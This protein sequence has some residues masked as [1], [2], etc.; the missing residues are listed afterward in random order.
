MTRLLVLVFAILALA[1]PALA[2][3]AAPTIL[4]SIDGFR[5]DYLGQGNTPNLDALVARGARAEMR[6]SFPTKTFPNHS[7]I[8]SG[9]V[10]DH[11]GIVSNNMLDPLR[12]GATFSLGNAKQ[13]L[14]AFWWDQL[15]PLW[16]TA[17]KAG[18]R[19]ATMF[20]PGSEV[21]I[22]GVRPHD[23]LRYDEAV[24]N[25]QRVNT[26]LDWM[27][28]PADIRPRFVTLYF[29]TVD[30]AGHRFA[31]DSLELIM[32]I[33]EVDARIGDLVA[34]LAAM[35]REANLVVVSDHGMAPVSDDRVIQL[36]DII[37]RAAYVAIDTGPFAGIEPAVGT[38][39]R[40]YDALLK[41]H[42]HMQCWRKQ[43]IPARFHYGTNPRVA[44]IF[45][46]AENGWSILSGPPPYPLV[47]GTHGWD[48]DSAD[49]RAL[50]IAAGP[51]IRRGALPTFDNVDVYPLLARLIGVTPLASDGDPETL[52]GVVGR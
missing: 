29:D 16:V 36:D 51:R 49:M 21:A 40:V 10:P 39:E 41:P 45:C 30:T 5:P 20:W 43:D 11:S 27:R 3:D 52:A 31:P 12:P 4:I 28:R 50:F 38:D 17:E 47:G 42:D 46:L 37:E 48:N 33:K 1:S 44:A 24:G 32:A 35:G 15:E 23:W 26:V 8:V 18:V 14:D 6:P 13:S 19:T 2:D 34:G 7:A 25:V 9:L 22:K